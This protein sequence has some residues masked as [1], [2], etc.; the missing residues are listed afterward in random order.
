MQKK[1]IHKK[2]ERIAKKTLLIYGE[3]LCEEVFLKH[4]QQYYSYKTD[5]AVRIRKG[6]GGDIRSLIIDADRVPG[7]YNQKI[8]ITDNDRDKNEMEAGRKESKKRNIILIE[9][10]PCLEAILLSVLNNGKVFSGKKTDWCKNEFQKKY[11]EERKRGDLKKYKKVFPKKILDQQES[12]IP[13][14]KRLIN[15]VKGILE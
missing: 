3:G 11:I 5:T 15:L 1:R 4:L 13:E 10:T 9:H 2:K 14:L 6:K 7:D 8:V 12:K